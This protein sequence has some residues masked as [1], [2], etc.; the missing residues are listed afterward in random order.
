MSQVAY[1]T[2]KHSI[3][4]S[5]RST[6]DTF[7]ASDAIL[8]GCIMKPILIMLLAIAIGIV[9][10]AVGASWVGVGSQV[11]CPPS[12][13]SWTEWSGYSSSS[14]GSVFGALSWYSGAT[15]VVQDTDGDGAQGSNA[16]AQATTF[17]LF[18]QGGWQQAG[19]HNHPDS[20]TYNVPSYEEFICGDTL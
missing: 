12:G 9:P 11:R 8:K 14:S 15:W 5:V 16:R 17:A 3:S 13:Q 4:L 2:P 7:G 18:A 19:V 20:N 1:R 10:A 6:L